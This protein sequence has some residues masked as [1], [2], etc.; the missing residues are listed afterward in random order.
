[1]IITANINDKNVTTILAALFHSP[2]ALMLV[3]IE[4]FS[5]HNEQSLNNWKT[6]S[7]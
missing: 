2:D 6:M 5:K 3:F 4:T 7:S 1:N